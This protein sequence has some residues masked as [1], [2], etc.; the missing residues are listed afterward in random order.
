MD[1]S[2]S[3]S[4]SVPICKLERPRR[5]AVSWRN[6]ACQGLDVLATQMLQALV[7]VSKDHCNYQ[8]RGLLAANVSEDMILLSGF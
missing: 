6:S 7:S 4:L 3:P 5:V 2:S 1:S 8:P